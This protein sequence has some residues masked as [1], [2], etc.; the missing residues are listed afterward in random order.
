MRV[1]LIVAL[2]ALVLAGCGLDDDTTSDG[3]PV[4]VATTTQLADLARQV[5]GPDAD[6]HQ[7]LQPNTD[8]HEYEPRP[9]DVATAAARHGSC[10]RAGD[11]LDAWMPGSSAR[12]ARRPVVDVGARVPPKL[13]GGRRVRLAPTRTGGT[14]R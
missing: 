13:R 12:R 6:V 5:A 2:A 14:T 11:G 10:S 3:R 1:I 7:L 4:V 8:P 9:K